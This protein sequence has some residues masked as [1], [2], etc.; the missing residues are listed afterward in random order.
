ME[1]IYHLIPDCVQDLSSNFTFLSLIRLT[2]SHQYYKLFMFEIKHIEQKLYYNSIESFYNLRT[3]SVPECIINYNISRL[4]NLQYFTYIDSKYNCI[5][6]HL[7]NLK[8]VNCDALCYRL[9]TELNKLENINYLPYLH[10]V[11]WDCLTHFTKLTN[12]DISLLPRE[13]QDYNSI[14]QFIHLRAIQCRGNINIDCFKSLK[15]LKKLRLHAYDQTMQ[16]F[17]IEELAIY[18]S[19]DVVINRCTNLTN[20]YT[21]GCENMQIIECFNIRKIQFEFNQ[22]PILIHFLTNL[23]ILNI[24]TNKVQCC[25]L[26]FFPKLN[27][28][29]I[30]GINR[31]RFFNNPNN[32]VTSLNLYPHEHIDYSMFHRLRKLIFRDNYFLNLSCLTNLVDLEIRTKCNDMIDLKYLINLTSLKM[33]EKDNVF[34]N[35]TLLTNLEILMLQDPKKPIDFNCL[36]KLRV[37]ETSFGL[38]LHN[39]NKLFNL[40][41]LTISMKPDNMICDGE[42]LSEL[43]KLTCLLTNSICIGLKYLKN[44]RV[45]KFAVKENVD[46]QKERIHRSN[47]IDIMRMINLRD[48]EILNYGNS[49]HFWVSDLTRLDN[50]VVRTMTE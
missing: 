48:L 34:T 45:L 16:D 33:F 22:T 50:Y 2:S 20:L 18:D 25:G 49:T 7:T 19:N 13:F 39:V 31:M 32:C 29:S 28:V 8:Y 23:E 42:M 41:S 12:L 14:L 30:Y 40:E 11:S 35:L 27:D 24:S 5:L 3:L 10:T 9:P 15:H 26:S 21:Q 46:A 6:S 17:S 47:K 37:L 4:T 44:V 38:Y 43:T 1:D 36:K